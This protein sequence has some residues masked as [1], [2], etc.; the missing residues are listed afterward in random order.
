MAALAGA[1]LAS[2]AAG[3]AR[4]RERIDVRLDRG[5]RTLRGRLELDLVNPAPV[6]LDRVYL[7]LYP[8]RLARPPSWVNDVTFYWVYPGR[9]SRGSMS[10]TSVSAQVAGRA[11]V[12]VPPSGWRP[13]PHAAAGKRVLWSVALP[14]PLAPGQAL[15]LVVGY[16]ARIP[17][18]FGT[19]GC[20]GGGCTLAGGFYPMPAA[21]D[22]A[23]WN[24]EAEPGVAD[25]DVTVTLARPAS[26]V[27]FDQWSGDGSSQ[28]RVRAP[29]AEYATLVVAPHFHVQSRRVAGAT[30]RYLSRAPPPPADDA[31]HVLLAYTLEDVGRYVLDTAE[32]AQAVL[33]D[34]DPRL[35]P[36]SLTVVEAP[37]RFQLASAHEHVILLSDRFYRI[38]PAER[39]RK[40][41][42]RQ[43]ARAVFTHDLLG[44]LDPDDPDRSFTAD[45]VAAHLAAI[46]VLEKYEKQEFLG[47]I[48]RPVSF[49]PSIDQLLYAPQT[50]FA[51]AY[52]GTASES[53]GVRDDPRLFM[54]TRP[55]GR[56]FY[57]KL[58][59]LMA[60]RALDQAMRQ[61]VDGRRPLRPALARA[62]GA[63]LDWFFRQWDRPS[64]RINYRLVGERSAPV[65]GAPGR[66]ANRVLIEREMEPGVAQVVEPLSVL[67]VDRDGTHHRLRWSGLGRTGVVSYRSASPIDW[68]WVDPDGDT[69]QQTVSTPSVHPRFD[70]L[71]HH[72]L[73]LVYNS[74]GVLLNLTDLSALLAADFTLSRVRDLKNSV[75]LTAYT[76]AAVLAG[77]AVSYRRGFGPQVTQ[78]ELLR[79]AALTL[80]VARLNTGFFAG[81]DDGGAGAE[82]QP[83][84]PASQLSLTASLSRDTEVFL[85]EPLHKQEFRLAGTVTVTRR[86]AVEA[87]GADVLVSG[88]VNLSTSR[89]FTPEAGHTLAGQLD[90][91]VAFG[92]IASRS[93]LLSGGGAEGVR[94]FAPGALFGRARL[95]ARGE[96]RQVFVHDLDWNLG[97]YTFVRG[98]GGVA[99]FDMGMLTPC[100]GYAPRASGFYTAAGYGLQVF[101][102]SFGTLASVMRVD[103]AI[104]L[105][106]SPRSCL[107][108]TAPEG[109]ELQLYV[110]FVPPF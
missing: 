35:T 47:Q 53:P 43:L 14:A 97:Q 17:E 19:F 95:I 100:T 61:V 7:W 60:R 65:A 110:S 1:A 51:E 20:T 11:R 89:T 80:G 63:P 50:L 62:R 93:Q 96:Y 25:L 108:V 107:G 76:S 56:F 24:L 48:L 109:P 45:L 101:Y 44:R 22:R 67:A 42:R 103:A 3:S 92:D 58:R 98:F 74:F 13:E 38:W 27:L 78:D 41:H 69:L 12:P 66:F 34:I 84:R 70:D 99:F 9:V 91:G 23:G 32:G 46:Y 68:A 39:F 36:R 8:N 28:F 88:D 33:A 82:G 54:N 37:L 81:A 59:G 104:K 71:D 106:G 16:R 83:A 4:L 52:F 75:R 79:H 102:D 10:L 86:D 5:A 18:R 57:D 49:V 77:G 2:P 6:A 15:H 29:A 31:R 55:R 90:L 26:M 94:G 87:A 72:P 85:F 105:A 73:R 21:L 40:F 30:V 64:P